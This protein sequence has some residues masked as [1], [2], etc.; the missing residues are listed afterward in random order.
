MNLIT[1]L[2]RICMSGRIS[3]FHKVTRQAIQ[4]KGNINTNR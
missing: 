3:D 1:V 2:R 4:V